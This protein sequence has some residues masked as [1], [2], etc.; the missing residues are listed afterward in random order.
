M[1]GAGLVH[2]ADGCG[3]GE[4]EQVGEDGGA[5]REKPICY[6]ITIAEHTE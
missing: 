3:W 4:V 1:V 2:P 5:G 6:G